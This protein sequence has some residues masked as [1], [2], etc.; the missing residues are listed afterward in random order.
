MSS[1]ALVAAA[2]LVAGLAILCVSVAVQGGGSESGEVTGTLTLH[3]GKDIRTAELKYVYAEA[4][5][6]NGFDVTFTDQ[7]L[8]EDPVERWKYS[9]LMSAEGKLNVLK[10]YLEPG[11]KLATSMVYRPITTSPDFDSGGY[12]Y[13]R[14]GKEFDPEKYDFKPRNDEF[15][16]L[17]VHV[18]GNKTIEGT[19]RSRL[20]KNDDGARYPEMKFQYQV[21]F[22]ARITPE[23]ESKAKTLPEGGGEPGKTYLAFYAAVMTQDVEKIKKAVTVEQAKTFEGTNA[24]KRAAKLKALL[25]PLNQVVGSSYATFVSNSGR[26]ARV[27]ISQDVQFVKKYWTD[28]KLNHTP[29]APLTSFALSQLP[30][31]PQNHMRAPRGYNRVPQTAS[32]RLIQE[33]GQWKIDWLLLYCEPVNL[34]WHLDHYQTMEERYEASE[35]VRKAEEPAESESVEEM[36]EIENGTPL[37]A[38]GGEAGKAYLEFCAAEKAGNKQA[39]VKYLHGAQ[40]ALYADPALTITRGAFIWKEGSSLH[41]VGIRVVDGISDGSR[42]VLNVQAVRQ[43]RNSTGRVLMVLED[44]QWK[45]DTEKWQTDATTKTAPRKR[46]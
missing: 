45:V 1:K 43:G 11:G 6:N 27:M 38:G 44:R 9:E 2:H 33:A 5:Q 32:V 14:I 3:I 22:K 25:L 26:C 35:K 12:L 39:V 37:T 34:F 17:N 10:L 23:S 29:P 31:D 40:A 16:E 36:F 18:T 15:A 8:P 30:W 20:L 24:K 4:D 21:K 41:Y 28:A 19:I 46:R 13:D 42:A 7:P